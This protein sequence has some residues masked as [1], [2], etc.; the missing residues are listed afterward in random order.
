MAGLAAAGVEP[1][2]VSKLLL[3]HIHLDHAGAGGSLMPLLPNAVVYVHA[4]GAPHLADPS[5]LLRSATRIYGEDMDRLWGDVLPV[6]P[7]RLKVLHDGESLQAGGRELRALYTPGHASHHVAYWDPG[8]ASV[9]TGDVG[10]IRL[11]GVAIPVPPTP[12]P[13][14]DLDAWS[15]S[16]DELL[17]LPASTLYLTHYGPTS[18][19]RSH[20]Q[21]LQTRLY[22]WRD[23][24]L[25]A[26]R[27][28]LEPT[29]VALLLERH[30]NQ[31]LAAPG[32]DPELRERYKLVSGYEMNVAGFVRYF[33]K[34][35][36][37]RP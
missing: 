16:I 8:S 10:G 14:L 23:L 24:V 11:P 27:R 7:D 32:A 3:T 28:G 4:A 25:D 17:R 31:E 29:E 5:R 36:I 2:R 18:D 30:A 26:L 15:A 34:Q 9:F 35:G 33:E 37:Y 19:V 22:A 20:L 12:P 1:G 6:P 21:G 13:D